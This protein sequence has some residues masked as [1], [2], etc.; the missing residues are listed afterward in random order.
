M[1]NNKINNLN[2][3]FTK[4]RINE[5]LKPWQVTGLVD[6]EGGFFVSISKIDKGL[7]GFN[8]K[9]E[10]KVTQKNHSEGILHEL[11]EYFSCG[12]VVIDNRKT[13]T[14]KYQIS[15]LTDILNIIIPHFDKYPC[16]TSKFINFKDWK[17]IALIMSE[18]GHLTEKGMK[19]ILNLKS[20]MNKDRSF[21]EKYNFCIKSLLKKNNQFF[22]LSPYWVQTFL[23][24]EGMFYN[25]IAEKKSRGIVYQGCD[26]SL[27]IAQNSHDVAVLLAIKNFFNAG[28]VKP[29]YDFFNLSE[30]LNSRTINRYI[31]RN[32]KLIIDFVDEYPILTRKH[33]DYLDWKKIV[34]LKLDGAHKTEEGLTLMK[35]IISNMNSKRDSDFIN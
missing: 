1:K 12:N 24:S 23:N 21:E 5:K 3:D 13:N 18:K 34:E 28:Y 32:T 16:L 33:L 26:S 4:P 17:K 30:C 14:K 19:N 29:K 15:A 6:G 8:L 25:Y 31:L 2:Y 27:E 20:N 7:I 9:L 22:E 35:K 11:K 10:F